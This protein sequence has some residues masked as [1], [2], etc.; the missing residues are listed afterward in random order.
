VREAAEAMIHRVQKLIP[1]AEITGFTVQ[2]M[3]HR[4]GAEELI[5]GMVDDSIFGPVILFGQGGIAVEIIG[6]RAVALPPMNMA[7]ASELIDRTRISRLLKGYR[8]R[9]GADLDAISAALIRV[10]QLVI[11]I[12]EVVELDINPLFADA[13]G[14]LALDARMRV[15]AATCKGP[16]RLAIRPYPQEL[17]ATIQ[18]GDER[19]L[20]RPI[21]PEDEPAH[22]DFVAHCDPDDIYFR[23]FRAVR[24][25]PHSE[26]ARLTQIDY[27]REMAFI[28]VADGGKGETI[29]VVRAITDPDNQ[30]A[31]FGIMVRS[32]RKGTGLGHALLGKMVDYLRAQGTRELRAHV[33]PANH[34]MLSLAERMGFTHRRLPEDEVTAIRLD[35]TGEEAS[36][37]TPATQG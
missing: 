2:A 1:E 5:V 36:A 19:I 24:H 32:D 4:P 17:E 6:D 7:L 35:L 22:Q 20:L 21:R 25:I 30:M 8:D 16:E 34:A 29:G 28:A 37:K 31:E 23:F 12:P 27:A 33:L 13:K 26:M 14:V 18:L 10:A 11:D 9:P 3:A 15:R